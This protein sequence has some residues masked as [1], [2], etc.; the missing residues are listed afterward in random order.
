M[1]LS[2]VRAGHGYG[3]AFDRILGLRSSRDELSYVATQG[4]GGEQQ[5]SRFQQGSIRKRVRGKG[6]VWVLRYYATRD[7]DGKR[8]ERTLTVGSVKKF[9]SESS[10]WAE[11]ERRRVRERINGPGFTGA[12][13]VG[14]L[15]AHYLEHE[16]ADQ[17][18]A[19]E[20]RSHT[21]VSAYR[22]VLRLRILPR[23]GKRIATSIKPLEV[24]QWLKALKSKHG[25][26][27][28]TLAKTRSVMSLVFRHGIRHSLITG[29][30]GSNPLQ[31]VRCRTTSDFEAQT[32]QPEQAFSIWQLLPEPERLLLLL[33]ACTGVRVRSYRML[34]IF[35][36]IRATREN[37]EPIVCTHVSR[38][39][40]C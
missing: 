13:T 34:L 11:I 9:P 17:S 23:W 14:D 26:A 37:G 39:I 35:R 12:V 1:A 21:T 18:L 22:R 8:V 32:I 38:R 20:P 27:N 15:V 29:G 30:D 7:D 19:I 33:A 28:P 16:L 36:L 3:E 5:L 31:Y 40:S 4:A 25:L 10:V 24:E 6:A 2:P